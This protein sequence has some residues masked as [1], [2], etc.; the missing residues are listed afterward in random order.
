M[1]FQPVEMK[2]QSIVDKTR[3]NYEQRCTRNHGS[4]SSQSLEDH[5]HCH[6]AQTLDKS[7]AVPQLPPAGAIPH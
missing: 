1:P 4:Q 2:S 7:R 3:Y 6:L 5:Q